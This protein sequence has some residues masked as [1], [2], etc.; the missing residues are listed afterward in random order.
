MARSIRGQPPESEDVE[1]IIRDTKLSA[2]TAADRFAEMAF[3]EKR[4][5]GKWLGNKFQLVGGRQWY[6]VHLTP[7]Y[8]GW[9]IEAII[10][11]S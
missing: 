10:Q 3:D 6:E 7:D 11:Q 5:V 4:K 8:T 1:M 9:S 2:R